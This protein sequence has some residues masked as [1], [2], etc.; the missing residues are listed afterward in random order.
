MGK[1]TFVKL[2]LLTALLLTLP[3]HA[4][5]WTQV[6]PDAGHKGIL[7]RA[8]LPFRHAGPLTVTVYLPPGYGDGTRFPVLYVMDGHELF[9]GTAGTW[10]LDETL[11]ALPGVEK[12]IVVGIHMNEHF[13]RL[14]WLTAVETV[15]PDTGAVQGGHARE[16][17]EDL[18]ETKALIDRTYSTQPENTGLMGSSLGGLFTLYAG[19]KRPEVFQRLAVM[20]PSMFLTHRPIQHPGE[21]WIPAYKPWPRKIW[22]DFGT[23][24]GEGDAEHTRHYGFAADEA[25]WLESHKIGPVEF[26]FHRY[27]A[28]TGASRHNEDSWAVRV[29]EALPWL[30]PAR[31]N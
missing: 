2:S 4:Q 3:A 31:K 9:D 29:R 15:Q 1:T 10:R 7:R 12:L 27:D 8:V 26:T 6:P 20:S 23:E 28:S 17:L 19:F 5:V 30:Y 22:M 25:S 21:E 24:E 11:E 13:D 14:R 18:L 16:F